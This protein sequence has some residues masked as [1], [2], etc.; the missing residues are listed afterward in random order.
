MNILIYFISILYL[1]IEAIKA[2]YLC[3]GL[4]GIAGWLSYLFV[5]PLLLVVLK[6]LSCSWVSPEISDG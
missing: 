2:S 1:L 3:I 4:I 6:Y 5:P